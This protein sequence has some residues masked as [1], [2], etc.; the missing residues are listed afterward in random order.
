MHI[1]SQNPVLS[2]MRKIAKNLTCPKLM[3]STL[4]D[5]DPDERLEP[6]S[7]AYS[8]FR[9]IMDQAQQLGTFSSN[10]VSRP[11]ASRSN[12]AT[13]TWPHLS[14][15]ELGFMHLE[16]PTLKDLCHRHKD[17]LRDLKL[18]FVALDD[19][20]KGDTWAVAG[21][22]LGSFLKLRS[23]T[24]RGLSTYLFADNSFTEE[25]VGYEIM[26]WIPKRTL[27]V[28]VLEEIWVEMRHK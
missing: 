19:M 15:L 7:K 8:A 18:V 17:T 24:L 25:K 23:L 13:A 28:K 10:M 20:D 1:L 14:V 16:L 26:R 2:S 5:D 12:Y 21:K 11:R 22:E 27:K 9:G 6:E 3:A 4:V